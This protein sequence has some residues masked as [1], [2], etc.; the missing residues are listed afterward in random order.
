M[1]Q[2]SQFYVRALDPKEFISTL[3]PVEEIVPVYNL[4]FGPNLIQPVS[5]KMLIQSSS[6]EYRPTVGAGG[7]N[8]FEYRSAVYEKWDDNALKR[9]WETRKCIEV[10]V[11]FQIG[12]YVKIEKETNSMH[13]A[14]GKI[15]SI[16]MLYKF[17]NG[18]NVSENHLVKSTSSR[19]VIL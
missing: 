5:E 2:K 3:G 1:E 17:Q 13:N 7:M 19:C 12:D 18:K 15:R 4:Q 8:L 9:D 16:K 14:V 11:R 10:P 6:N